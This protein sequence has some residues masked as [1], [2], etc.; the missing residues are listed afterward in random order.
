MFYIRLIFISFTFIVLMFLLCEMTTLT[1]LLYPQILRNATLFKING[2]ELYNVTCSNS[3]DCSKDL[4]SLSTPYNKVGIKNNDPINHDKC[5]NSISDIYYD[6]LTGKFGPEFK[7]FFIIW[8]LSM[9]M[10][11][12]TS[13]YNL[14]SIQIDNIKNAIV[15]ICFMTI[16]K[17][18]IIL[19]I[20]IN[21]TILQNHMDNII[22]FS[23]II[24]LMI[25]IQQ[26]I[27]LALEFIKKISNYNTYIYM[28]M[29]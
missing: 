11:I 8:I 17:I 24:H 6:L 9:L 20:V 27:D 1:T 3:L 18:L 5:L 29:I 4:C 7:L 26:C 2:D 22:I 21:F 28:T 25:L 23:I 10:Y 13:I 12:L 19:L 15:Y 14:L 16:S